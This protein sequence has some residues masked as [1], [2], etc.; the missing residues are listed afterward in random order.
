MYIFACLFTAVNDDWL[1][2]KAAIPVPFIKLLVSGFVL[3]VSLV[4]A[5]ALWI[6]LTPWMMVMV[7]AKVIRQRPSPGPL[8]R[9]SI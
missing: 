3:T 1:K 5:V 9:S 4:W 8:L 2:A 7:M 6:E